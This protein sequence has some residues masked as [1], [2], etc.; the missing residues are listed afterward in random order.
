MGGV[1]DLIMGHEFAGRVAD[2]GNRDD[3]AKGDRVTALPLDPCGTCAACRAGHVNICSKALKRSIP[4]NNSPGGFAEFLKVRPDMVRKLPDCIN[5]VQ[6][7]M[8][9]P[10][11][12]ALHAVRTA[13]V[14]P[15]DKVMISGGGPIGLLCAAWAKISGVSFVAL[16]E[17][18][19]FRQEFARQTG[20]AAA[21]F[22][23]SGPGFAA[24]LM[25]KTR[26]GFDAVIETS[27]S[28]AGINLGLRMLRPRGRLVLAGINDHTQAILTIMAA[29]R[30]ITQTS[31]M[32]YLPEE[33]DTTMDYIAEQRIDVEKL[34]TG[35]TALAGL[36][37]AFER[38]AS[39][40]SEDIKIICRAAS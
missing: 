8:I 11:A 34:V 32:G 16:T 26:G 33:F 18:S 31:V 37:P 4:G 24:K 40:T 9:E 12:V 3:L 23:P 27:A 17:I 14:K 2:P 20:D 10:G 6:A 28:D 15:G 7:A 36:G 1:H 25:K 38:L 35:T 30:E 13:G 22:D 29:V 39:G 5:D 19:R 21:G